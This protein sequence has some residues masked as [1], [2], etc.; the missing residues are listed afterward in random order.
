MI[1]MQL[2]GPFGFSGSHALSSLRSMEAQH[3]DAPGTGPD[4]YGTAV[5]LNSCALLQFIC[6]VAWGEERTPTGVQVAGSAGARSSPQP[7]SLF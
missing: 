2:A 7:T 1:N 5:Q 6:T 4:K 3:T